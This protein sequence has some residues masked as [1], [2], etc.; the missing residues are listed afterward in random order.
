[1]HPIKQNVFL[2]QLQ[3][4]CSYFLRVIPNIEQAFI[5]QDTHEMFFIIQVL[6]GTS[7]NISRL[8]WGQKNARHKKEILNERK[9]LREIL[10]VS[11]DSALRDVSVRNGFEHIDEKIDKWWSDSPNKECIDKIMGSIEVSLYRRN[12]I[13]VFRFYDQHSFKVVFWGQT[14][15]IIAVRLEVLKIAR[16]LNELDVV[17]TWP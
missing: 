16:A 8:L 2:R 6:L 12:D 10:G 4:Q 7:A 17:E 5:E 11:D 15:D 14:F 9:H 3:D 13:D 1:M